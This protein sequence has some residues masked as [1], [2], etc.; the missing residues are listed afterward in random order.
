MRWT[1]KIYLID[2]RILYLTVITFR[3]E[4]IEA[5]NKSA[6]QNDN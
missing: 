2:E 5:L 6:L 4:E 3:L 1:L